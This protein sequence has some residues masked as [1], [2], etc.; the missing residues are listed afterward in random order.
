M[1]SGYHWPGNVRE[2]EN[3]VHRLVVMAEGDRVSKL[4]TFRPA[5][6]FSV[7]RQPDL[8]R[9]LAEVEAEYI[10][11]VLAASAETGRRRRKS[12]AWTGRRSARSSRRRRIS[13]ES[14]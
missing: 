2:L 7:S 10:R 3:V 4:P 1:K 13:R 12:S 11:N 5:M 8:T 6:R 14:A 9:T